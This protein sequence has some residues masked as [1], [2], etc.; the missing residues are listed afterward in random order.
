MAV[1]WNSEAK[2]AIS[3]VPFFVRKRVKKRVKEVPQAVDACLDYYQGNCHGGERF[4]EILER[5]GVDWLE[6]ERKNLKKSRH[7]D[8]SQGKRQTHA[9]SFR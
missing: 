1:R 2:K 8:L 7:I 5:N 9:L 6:K 3:R 4:G